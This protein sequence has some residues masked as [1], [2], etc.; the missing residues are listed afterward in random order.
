MFSLIA[1]IAAPDIV[2]EAN[3]SRQAFCHKKIGLPKAQAFA[4]KKTYA[5][6]YS[7]ENHVISDSLTMKVSQLIKKYS[8]FIDKN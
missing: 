2:E 5:F 4:L 3:I 6:S 7:L 8:Q 1:A